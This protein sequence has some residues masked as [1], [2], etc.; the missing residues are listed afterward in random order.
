MTTI[1]TIQ[2]LREIKSVIINGVSTTGKTPLLY[3]CS[4]AE[5]TGKLFGLIDGDYVGK[6]LASLIMPSELYKVDYILKGVT[7][8]NEYFMLILIDDVNINKIY[9][10]LVINDISYQSAVFSVLLEHIKQHV[11]DGT[12][13]TGYMLKHTPTL[14]S[15]YIP[16]KI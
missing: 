11:L 9:Y 7:K 15:S 16:L 14:Q 4:N 13:T 12:L 1:D 10:E 6:T 5:P 8:T 2:Q 3:L